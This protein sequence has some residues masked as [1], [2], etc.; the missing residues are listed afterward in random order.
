MGTFAK[1]DDC[2]FQLTHQGG[3]RRHEIQRRSPRFSASA[4]AR[5][6]SLGR[7]PDLTPDHASA[8]ALM[9]KKGMPPASGVGIGTP[10]LVIRNTQILNE[11][12]RTTSLQMG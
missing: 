12:I 8:F 1:G 11:L 9:R 5:S 3:E 10:I 7:F 4:V 2:V 6:L